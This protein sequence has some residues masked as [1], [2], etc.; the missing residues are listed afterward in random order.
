MQ[1]FKPFRILLGLSCSNPPGSASPRQSTFAVNLGSDI[2]DD[3]AKAHFAVRTIGPKFTT[4][5]PL[6][7]E[8]DRETIDGALKRSRDQ[9][10]DASLA[11]CDYEAGILEDPDHDSYK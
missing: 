7:N 6:T 9:S 3:Q 1:D 10:M 5:K 2:G 8:R 4:Q 11:H